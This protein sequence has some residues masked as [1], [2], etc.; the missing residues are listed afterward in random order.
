MT[1]QLLLRTLFITT[2]TLALAGTASAQFSD[3]DR[4]R[5]NQA[6]FYN[7]TQPGDGIENTS[8]DDL[9]S[10]SGQSVLHPADRRQS[11]RYVTQVPVGIF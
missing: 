8:G 5:L 6:A 3:L 9:A 7:Y 2:L 10:F 1:R 4:S 11:R